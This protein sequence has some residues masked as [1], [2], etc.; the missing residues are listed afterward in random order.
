MAKTRQPN[1][2]NEFVQKMY[3]QVNNFSQGFAIVILI[4]SL[5]DRLM[6][7]SRQF[8]LEDIYVFIFA[9]TSFFISLIFWTRYYFDTE[10]IK[11]S[12]SVKAVVWFFLYIVSEG[13]SFRQVSEPFYWLISTG[14]FLLFGCGFYILNLSEIGYSANS[15]NASKNPAYPLKFHER[16]RRWFTNTYRYLFVERRKYRDW[17][18]ERLVDMIVLAGLSFI[19][20]WLVV[21]NPALVYPIAIFALSFSLWQLSKTRDYKRNRFLD[22]I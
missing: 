7:G 16:V 8:V 10:I 21:R 9:L 19:G 2:P 12:F 18:I 13:F 17:Q 20:G 3:M 14:V 1:Q 15:R 5:A 6:E 4:D 11:R 22:R